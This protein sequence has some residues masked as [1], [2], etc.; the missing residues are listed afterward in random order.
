MAARLCRALIALAILAT[1]A[2]GT[3]ILVA[4]LK[5]GGQMVGAAARCGAGVL[6][7]VPARARRSDV[8]RDRHCQGHSGLCAEP[9]PVAVA[10]RAGPAGG[11]A[12]VLR[13]GAGGRGRVAA[14][15][16][17]ARHAGG[18]RRTVRA[19]PLPGAR[20]LRRARP[21]Q[22]RS[23]VPAAMACSRSAQTTGSSCWPMRR[24]RANFTSR[25]LGKRSR[26]GVPR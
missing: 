12:P 24:R 23:P 15:P 9:V 6:G 3:T 20:R 21:S 18:R 5:A 4:R 19:C 16:A 11:G 26:Q 14:A 2:A 22:T 13:A 25:V 7:G 10:C 1:S 17:P 8:A